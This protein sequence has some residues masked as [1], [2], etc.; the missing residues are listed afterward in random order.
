MLILLRDE[1]TGMHIARMSHYCYLLAKEARCN[2]KFIKNI[3]YASTMHDVGKIGIPDH[4]LLKNG[5]LDESEYKIMQTHSEIGKELLN[6]S[7]VDLLILAESIAHTHHEKYDGTGYP[8]GLKGESI[9]I[10]G[11]IAAI[12]DVFDALVSDRPYKKG[13]SNEEAISLIQEESGKHFDPELV[14]CFMNIIPDVLEYQK[15][16]QEP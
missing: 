15:T 12:C 7:D 4:I 5:K 8:R 11:R 2:K 16:H 3:L 1:E 6:G 14:N 9:P 13:W 10:E